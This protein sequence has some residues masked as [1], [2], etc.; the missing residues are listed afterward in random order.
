M[1]KKIWKSLARM[2]RNRGNNKKSYNYQ[3]AQTDYLTIRHRSKAEI[4]L[5]SLDNGQT[6]FRTPFT[7]RLGR[8][9]IHLRK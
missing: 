6:E 3:S 2:C 1:F 4:N 9:V 8:K 7:T 5:V